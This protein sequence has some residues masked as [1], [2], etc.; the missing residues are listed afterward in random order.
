MLELNRNISAKE[1][2]DIANVFEIPPALVQGFRVG[3]LFSGV[4][5]SGKAWADAI[6][7]TLALM[8]L[9]FLA[10]LLF[11]KLYGKTPGEYEGL[12]NDLIKVEP[13]E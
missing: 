1:V 6:G 9:S 11:D 8:S 13:I 4:T 2:Q 10:T 7:T 3:E 5:P 12:F